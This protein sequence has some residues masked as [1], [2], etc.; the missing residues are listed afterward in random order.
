LRLLYLEAYGRCFEDVGGE[1]ELCHVVVIAFRPWDCQTNFT[2][3]CL[4]QVRHRPVQMTARGAQG[5]LTDRGRA[6]VEACRPPKPK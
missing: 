1:L 4:N 6:F 5:L 2:P 3:V